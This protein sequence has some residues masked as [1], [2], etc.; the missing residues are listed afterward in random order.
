M[1]CLAMDQNA[2]M[3]DLRRQ[4]AEAT[5]GL[6]LFRALF[7]TSDSGYS[8]QEAIYNADGRLVDF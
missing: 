6:A 8:I 2:L 1:Q 4:L 5:D 7:D 3:E